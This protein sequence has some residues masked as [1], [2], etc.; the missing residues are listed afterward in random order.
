[1][2]SWRFLATADN[3]ITEQGKESAPSTLCSLTLKFRWHGYQTRPEGVQAQD[4]CL[5]IIVRYDMEKKINI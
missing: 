3:I 1:M 2:N 5:R 4:R